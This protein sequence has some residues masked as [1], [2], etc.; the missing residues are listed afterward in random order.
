MTNRYL[1]AGTFLAGAALA[2]CIAATS[3]PEPT[4]ELAKEVT[5]IELPD[6]PACETEDSTGCYWDADVQGNQSGVDIVTQPEA[7]APTAAPIETPAPQEATSGARQ[8]YDLGILDCGVNAKPAIDQDEFGNW[9]A[10]CE[11]ALID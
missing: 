2:L 3:T 5:S 7:P 8:D 1:I 4:P 10:Y 11:P 6:L 9:W